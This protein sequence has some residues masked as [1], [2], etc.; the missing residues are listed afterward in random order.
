MMELASAGQYEKRMSATDHFIVGIG[1][2]AGGISAME[3][4]FRNLPA[5]SGM[6]YVVVTH[7]SPTRESLLHEV[8]ARFTRLPVHIARDGAE[9]APDTVHVMPQN[10]ILSFRNGRLVLHDPDPAHRERKPIDVMF[11][12]LAEDRGENA[13]GII[14]SGGDSDGTLGVKAIKEHGGFTLAQVPNGSGP[15]NPEMPASAIAS[16][17][18]D[19]AVPAED[20]PA[21]LLQIGV[22]RSS[23]GDLLA[24]GQQ[25][26]VD[27]ELRRMQRE[28]STLLRS[29]SGN[30]FS[31]YKSKTFF[32][33]VARRMQVAH[34]T[35]LE[36][37]L[38]LLKR[39]P[40]E[41]MA[42]F[43]DLLINVTD[44]FR[45]AEAFE[46]LQE[47]VIPVLFE[48]RGADETIRIW[49]PACAT[50][51]EVY[52]LGILM[53]EQMDGL[54]VRPQVQ[55]F[56][57]DIDE[58]A[59]AVA[60]AARYPEQLLRN[61]SPER[62]KR[63]FKKDGA[64]YVMDKEVRDM[65]I[66][67]PHSV[68]SDPPFSRMDMVSCRNLLIYFA[69]DLQRQVIPIFHYALKPGGYLFLGTSESVSQHT[70]LFHP[71]DKKSRIFQSVDHGRKT[72]L[73]MSLEGMVSVTQRLGKAVGSGNTSGFQ[74]R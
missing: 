18:I 45:D 8:I 37:Y 21:K 13:I 31:G 44:F 15:K 49:V 36:D 62:R 22:T 54:A 11:A 17:L 38:D 68:I 16:G 9:V 27:A 59:L 20:M 58:A 73:P 43:R 53:R 2:S 40:A 7:L 69:I 29:H 57:T 60:R 10:V 52:S 47:K 39:N 32:R 67:S 66:F 35:R 55:I 72:R 70:D 34:V 63:F 71:V 26:T 64:S 3:A 6:G 51:E 61:I 41:V 24:R 5:D 12:S 56:A 33:R 42:L 4:F 25:D 14:L 30:D 50:G 19:F 46:A 74:L 28:L 23:L 1:A 65:C 48:G